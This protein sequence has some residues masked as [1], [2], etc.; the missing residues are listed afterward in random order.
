MMILTGERGTGKT[1]ELIK[2]SEETVPDRRK[3]FFQCKVHQGTRQSH[4]CEDPGR[5]HG[6]AGKRQGS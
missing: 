2:F 1:S 4:G 6:N 3:K 5:I